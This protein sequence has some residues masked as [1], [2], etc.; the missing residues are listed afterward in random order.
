[1][2]AT[3]AKGSRIAAIATCT[4]ISRFDNLADTSAFPKDEVRKI[5]GMAGVYARRLADE[6]TCSSD[7]CIPAANLVVETLKWERESIDALIMV[8]QSPD[9]LLPSTSCVVH[10][11][12]GLSNHCASFDVG[13]GCSGYVYGLWLASMM[14]QNGAFQRILLLHG[15]TAGRFADKSDRSTALLFSDAGSA[16]ALESLDSDISDEFFFLLH[17]DGKGYEDMIIEAGGFRKRFSEDLRQYYLKMNGA[18]I[19]T[20]T[21]DKV[22]PLILK[23]MEYAG[24]AEKEIDYFVFHQANQFIIR[25]IISKLKIPSSKVPLTLREYGNTGGPSIPLTITRGELARPPDHSLKMMLLAYGVGLSWASALV[26][27]DSNAV[28]DHIDL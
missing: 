9:Y 8:T 15:E 22:P 18:S 20:F 3:R 4:P 10:N 19:F 28:L 7:L 13:L 17:T 2:P 11:H 14:L 27:L 24:V 16:T 1:M 6:G 12:L 26:T 23:T 5:V 25:H 21:I